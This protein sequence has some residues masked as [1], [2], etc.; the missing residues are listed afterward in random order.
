MGLTK[1]FKRCPECNKLI[2]RGLEVCPLCQSDIRAF[3]RKN[4]RGSEEDKTHVTIRL[5][6]DERA[7]L[8]DIKTILDIES[9]G[10]ALKISAFKGWDVLQRTLGRDYLKWLADKNRLSRNL[11]GA[12]NE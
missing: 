10:T 9:D 1:D 6:D 5:N 4:P 2:E 12:K 7:Q 3:I 8:D 11:K